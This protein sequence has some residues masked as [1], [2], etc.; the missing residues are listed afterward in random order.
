[1]RQKAEKAIRRAAASLCDSDS[2]RLDKVRFGA[3]LHRKVFDKTILDMARLGTIHL[4]SANT[5]ELYNVETG[6]LVSTGDMVY[7]SFTFADS[8][9]MQIEPESDSENEQTQPEPD[10]D[11][12]NK[13][14]QP[15]PE[16]I[17][18]I[19]Q[20][21]DIAEWETFDF[22]CKIREGL[23]PFQKIQEMITDYNRR[24]EPISGYRENTT[25]VSDP[26][27]KEIEKLITGMERIIET[28]QNSARALMIGDS[29][30]R[31]QITYWRYIM[32]DLR[33]IRRLLN[34]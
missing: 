21:I 10:A 16:S 14:V 25:D 24:N 4:N 22:N 19:M 32:Q 27:M 29:E 11:S 17:D 26:D 28:G 9:K 31:L 15:E 12:E 23:K 20:G 13:Q 3:G 1:M 8:E 6:D 5:E 18:S 34:I 33:D 30:Q 2:Y 7:I